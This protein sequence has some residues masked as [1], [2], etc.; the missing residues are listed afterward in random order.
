M[1]VVADSGP[2][3]YLILLEHIEL[4]GRIYGQVLVPEPVAS[5]LSAAGAPA[6][7][8][9]WIAKPPT[10]VDVR[11]VPSDAVSMI[12]DDLDL[13]ERAAIVLAETMRA[14]LLL[15]DEAAGRASTPA[16]DRHAGRTQGSRRAGPGKRAR[17]A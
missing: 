14:D 17:A 5:E 9:D 1:I 16:R 12:T 3:H 4:L 8:R 6:V 10:W 2:L 11:Q 15:I 7:V 13:G